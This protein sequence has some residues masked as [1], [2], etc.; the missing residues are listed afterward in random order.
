MEKSEIQ[1]G[2]L[3]Y[4][5][6]NPSPSSICKKQF[7]HKDRGADMSKEKSNS[8]V[9]GNQKDDEASKAVF[10]TTPLPEI[11][12]SKEMLFQ[13]LDEFL[14]KGYS[15]YQYQSLNQTEQNLEK[16]NELIQQIKN[17]L[18][19]ISKIE[20][21]RGVKSPLTAREKKFLKSQ[22]K[23]LE[24]QLFIENNNWTEQFKNYSEST[25]DEIKKA[26]DEKFIEM[27]RSG[28]Y[29]NKYKGTIVLRIKSLFGLVLDAD[30]PALSEFKDKLNRS[31]GKEA[32][33]LI[34]SFF[35]E[36]ELNP[37][38]SAFYSAHRDLHDKYNQLIKELL[39]EWDGRTSK[40]YSFKD[41]ELAITVE[42]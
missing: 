33:S 23:T 13:S 5:Q 14:P 32:D 36:N 39:D 37:F 29:V 42:K 4:F 18:K 15:S 34:L 17:L 2:F 10:S 25:Y 12:S 26:K 11:P 7:L 8:K 6:D 40:E 38:L 28:I 3:G 16:I 9:T 41:S 20:K 30:A 27:G 22:R 19:P 21:K 35:K 1:E 24:K 31:S